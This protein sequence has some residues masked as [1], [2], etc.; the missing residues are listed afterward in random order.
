MGVTAKNIDNSVTNFKGYTHQINN[1]NEIYNLNKYMY[2]V[3]SSEEGRLNTT[4]ETLKS[5]VLKARQ[6]YLS[7]DREQQLAK[8]KSRLLYLSIL[9]LCIVFVLIGLL[10]SNLLNIFIVS[11]A[12]TIILIIYLVVSFVWMLA[13]TDRRNTNWNQ[14]YWPQMNKK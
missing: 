7:M 2:D 10:M 5:A 14:Y 6:N 9:T 11:V 13:N 3:N 4:N 12:I 8:F 1:Y